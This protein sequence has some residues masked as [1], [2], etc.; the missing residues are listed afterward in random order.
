MGDEK[1][2]E[3]CE[4]RGRIA[5]KCELFKSQNNLSQNH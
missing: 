1:I 4:R 2:A 3:D 5:E